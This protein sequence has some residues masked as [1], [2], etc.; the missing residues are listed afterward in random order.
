[1]NVRFATPDDYGQLLPLFLGLREFSRAGHPPQDDDFDA[2]LAATR[3]YLHEVLERGSE[4]R[5]LLATQDG[6]IAGYL[7]VTVHEPNPLSSSGAVRT[8]SIDELFVDNAYR[9]LGAGSLLISAA[10]DWLIE[11]RARRV[12]VGAYAWNSAGIAF[13][14]REGFVPWTIAL[15]KPL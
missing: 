12:E 2:V 14:E 6:Q 11:Q 1:M 15:S 4:C 7:V 8:G 9:G 10:C 13:Y 3:E 5:T